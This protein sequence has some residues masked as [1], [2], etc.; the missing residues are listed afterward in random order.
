MW[1]GGQE[2]MMQTETQVREARSW[3]HQLRSD[4]ERHEAAR[5]RAW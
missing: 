4:L 2:G 5:G 3:V 1:N